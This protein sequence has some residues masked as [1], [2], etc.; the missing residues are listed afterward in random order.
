ME[1]NEV[2]SVLHFPLMGAGVLTPKEKLTKQDLYQIIHHEMV[3]SALA[4]K[5]GQ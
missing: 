2:N 1:F 5:I 3:A 4:V